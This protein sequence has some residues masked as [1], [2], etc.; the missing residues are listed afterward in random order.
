MRDTHSW[1]NCAVSADGARV[2]GFV[3]VAN[4]D[5]ATLVCGMWQR[6]RSSRTPSNNTHYKGADTVWTG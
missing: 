4:W 5:W 6:T 3:L 1:A 2:G